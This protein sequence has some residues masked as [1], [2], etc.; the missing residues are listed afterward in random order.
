MPTKASS[1][2][3]LHFKEN[4]ICFQNNDKS[5]IYVSNT[6]CHISN[7]DTWGTAGFRTTL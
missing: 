1:N 6:K 3:F 4:Y 5:E 2:T 7:V